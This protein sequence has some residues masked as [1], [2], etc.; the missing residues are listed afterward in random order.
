MRDSP[1]AGGSR[2]LTEFGSEIPL[3]SCDQMILDLEWVT[4]VN[5]LRRALSSRPRGRVCFQLGFDESRRRSRP[6]IDRLT[7]SV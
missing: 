4:V 6:S 2:K 7:L 1:L 3:I 5:A